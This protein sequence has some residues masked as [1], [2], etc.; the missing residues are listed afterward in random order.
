MLTIDNDRR[1]LTTPAGVF[2][3]TLTLVK[4]AESLGPGEKWITI[5]PHG[6]DG[7]GVPVIIREHPDGSASI[8]G[9]AGGKLNFLKLGKLRSKEEWTQSA[10]E[11]AVKKRKA[12]A[13]RVAAQS[14]EERGIEQEQTAKAKDYHQ[15]KTHENALKT[16]YTLESGGVDHG[17]TPE[18]RQALENP[19][20]A[21]AS[22]EEVKEWRATTREAAKKVREI[23]RAYE[24]RLVSDHEARSAA[25]A[26]EMPN[27][28]TE[29]LAHSAGDG[30]GNTIAS[31]QQ[32]P[33]GQWLATSE[34]GGKVFDR[35]DEA[36]KQHVRNVQVAEADLG[37]STQPE[38]F[39]E[40][41]QWVRQGDGEATFNPAIALEVAALGKERKENAR[42]ERAAQEAIRRGEAWQA[43]G[44]GQAIEPIR[45]E[46]IAESI[47]Q[48]AKALEDAAKN[49]QLLDL[50]DKFGDAKSL[51]K[52]VEQGGYGQLAEICSDVLKQ[53]PISR[54]IV[55]A[56]GYSEAAKVFAFAMKGAMSDRE[57]E[58]VVNAQQ[59]FHA[60]TSTRIAEATV[61]QVKPLS[62]ALSAL[63]EQMVQ[64]EQDM[65]DNP[66]PEQHMLMDSLS[67]DAEQ[68]NQDIQR[69]IGSAIGQLQASAAMSAALGGSPNV[70]R[71]SAKAA[72]KILPTGDSP[73]I[74]AA[75]GIESS[76]LKVIPGPDG[77]MLQ[78]NKSGMEKLSAGY[79]PEDRE[80]YDRAM[81]IKRG[82]LDEP[83]FVPQGFS[84]YSAASFSDAESAR[85][86]F[87]TSFSEIDD[88]KA[89]NIPE[90]LEESIAGYV[91]SRVA[92]GDNPLEVMQDIRSPEFYMQQGLE[93][94]GEAAMAVQGAAAEMVKRVAG[95]GNLSDSNIKKAFQ[96]MGDAEAAKQRM[97]RQT[98][99]LEA[100]HN[101]T[102]DR[103]SG[104]EAL[105]RT[106]AAMPM[107]R[108][109]FK[110]KL[111]VK[112]RRW[113]REYG[114]TEV[115]G[116]ELREPPK[117]EDKSTGL[118][119][120]AEEQFDLFGNPISA[121]EAA[122]SGE[123]DSPEISQWQEFSKLMGGDDR[124]YSAITD[125]LRGK[126]NHRFA[127]AYGAI[128]GKPPLIGG[129][130]IK[131]VDRLL[132]AKLPEAQR[133]EMLEFMKS[134]DASDK[135][136]AQARSGGKFVVDDEWR[137]RYEALKGDNRQISLLAADTGRSTP[138]TDYQRTTL[139][140]KAE[141]MLH[142]FAQ[143][144]APN[145]E[146]IDNSVGVIP[147][148]KWD[149]QHV[150][151][152]R[153]LKFLE[154]QRRIGL[155]AGAGSGK[156]AT[157]AGMFSH[158]YAQGKVKKMIFAVPSSIVGQAIGEM[159]TF[160]KAGTYKYN[161]N[162]GW[163]REQ[164]IAAMKDDTHIHLTTRESLTNDIMYLVDKHL[165][166][167]DTAFRS[168][169]E[170]EQ[171]DA[172]S[173]ALRTEGIEPSDVLLTV[174][175][176]HDI[177]A[178]KGVAPSKRSLA[179]NHFGGH[180]G[181]YVQAT[182]DPLK[183]DLSEVYNFLHSVAP[184]K[185][186]DQAKFLAEYSGNRRAL[187][188]AVAPYS[189]AFS[190]KPQSKD[191][192]VLRMNEEQPKIAANEY[193]GKGRQQILDDIKVLSDWQSQHREKLKEAKGETYQPTTEDFNAA[194]E[195][196]EVRAAIDRLGS[197]DTWGSFDDTQKQAAIGGQIRALGGLKRTA[198][199]RLYHRAPFEQNPKAQWTVDH[200][201]EQVKK[202]GEAGVVF[203]SSSQA[204]E[205]LVEQMQK[206][207]L[208][209][210]YIHG[211][212]SADQKTSERVKFQDKGEYDVLVCTDAAQ[213]GL[214]LTRGKWLTHYDVPLTDKAYGQRSARIHRLKQDQDTRVFVPMIDS[215]EEKIA[216]A[217][218]K[219]KAT[220][221]NPVKA[222]AEMLDDSGLAARLAS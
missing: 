172:I 99:D 92:N 61:K 64:L 31:L 83:D 76:D 174:D 209:V 72:E 104:V 118:S 8:V 187:Q 217:R 59:A 79:N 199:W 39:Y 81:A 35:W 182:G 129:D 206:R 63:H 89:G 202:T 109:L 205:M 58:G 126:F 70:L 166:I 17:I 21:D 144:V 197:D 131:N 138:K 60:E 171:K 95:G 9:G 219:R 6:E 139:G 134:R 128:S 86:D 110:E 177:T 193:I 178:R 100:L 218:M 15:S 112:E 29:N 57:Y 156:T 123:L 43:L 115:L 167:D 40:P 200:A 117:K 168:M 41:N 46:E 4:K 173:K 80:A 37:Y 116:Q 12:E 212:L 176:A 26:G 49:G 183:N 149:G 180:A 19:P 161:A 28:L 210:G 201:V 103:E 196:P 121:S 91:G 119:E 44:E 53:V 213:T 204:A 52:H 220:I 32:L 102:L 152:Q 222:K 94:Y 11:R 24:H 169:P 85:N 105:H 69:K 16:I 111:S 113:L 54:A 163:D 50:L 67:Y 82:E 137:D 27:N 33:N 42:N 151:K 22:P 25:M 93:P 106:L 191:G 5:H 73:G 3:F 170:S 122:D 125:H 7:K 62:E 162:L 96:E 55:D 36:A 135:A 51:K 160:L 190:T 23:Q 159:A 133:N 143:D 77:D 13:D 148:V 65:G 186:N 155:H 195:S 74:L 38:E 71:L 154:A 18:E 136:K 130:D 78:I 14:D 207:G 132:L 45:R 140:T 147:E 208:K 30:D 145:F 175:E 203:S 181:Y 211:G 48:D 184:D 185:F 66:T 84:H 10:R 124:A 141:D 215:P 153:A 98:D 189:Y 165:G 107:A 192:R 2:R 1:L 88:L 127:N 87:D 164:R 75:Y 146:Q 216:Y 150:T 188:R 157:A 221:G 20:S 47:K 214:N 68:L 97:A 34:D 142:K 158:L 120:L 101:Q 90:N 108:I 179:L 114:I 56:I 194:W 198:M